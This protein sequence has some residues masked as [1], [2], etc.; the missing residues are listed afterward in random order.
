MY[1]QLH[2]FIT[3]TKILINSNITILYNYIKIIFKIKIKNFRIYIYIQKDCSIIYKT[4]RI[5]FLI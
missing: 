1:N 5:H 2:Y 3:T 4:Y